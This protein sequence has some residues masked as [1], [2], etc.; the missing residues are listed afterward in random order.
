MILLSNL[1]CKGM[2]IHG[3]R[4]KGP[5]TL[6]PPTEEQF[7]SLISFL[8]SSADQATAIC[9]LPFLGEEINRPRWNPWHA[10]AFEHIF[11]D[12]YERRLSEFPQ[13]RQCVRSG[14]DWPELRDRTTLML[15]NQIDLYGE[16]YNTAEKIAAA[17]TNIRKIT[18]SSPMFPPQE[19]RKR[20]QSLP[21][22]RP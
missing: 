11:R 7:D 17:E 18:W 4:E 22:W 2:W 9:P 15:G 12:R 10:F 14:I 5:Q 20:L 19:H 1:K 3:N 6:Y 16:P 21:R 8:L 13:D